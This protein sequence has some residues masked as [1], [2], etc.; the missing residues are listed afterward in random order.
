[1]STDI[2]RAGWPE[3]I[4]APRVKE[5]EL[6]AML[7]RM[8][9]RGEISARVELEQTRDHVIA[10]VIRLK[11]HR[12]RRQAGI[13]VMA[14]AATGLG[15]LAGIGA[16][17]WEIRYLLAALAAGGICALLIAWASSHSA[18]CSGI[19]CGGCKG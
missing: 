7:R 14:L 2:A 10:Y 18:G 6:R 8:A 12:T 16:M 13:R 15:A 1:M 17:L 3:R 9:E 5:Q 19:H 4:T 11:A